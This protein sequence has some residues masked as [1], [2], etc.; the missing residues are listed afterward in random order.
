MPYLGDEIVNID[1]VLRQ[2]HGFLL[3]LLIDST[4]LPEF[5]ELHRER[6]RLRRSAIDEDAEGRTPRRPISLAEFGGVLGEP[7]PVRWIVFPEFA[8]GGETRLEEVGQAER[9]FRFAQ[10]GL[11]VHVW[12]DRAFTLMQEMLQSAFVARVRI[13]SLSNAAELLLSALPKPEG[14]DGS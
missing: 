13:G 10:A 11:N 3:P 14:G 6:P 8:P 2:A 1:P 5:P 12:R 9:V 7:Q 4:D